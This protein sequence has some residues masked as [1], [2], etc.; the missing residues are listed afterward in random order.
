MFL[1]LFLPEKLNVKFPVDFSIFLP[2]RY[3][4]GKIDSVEI[5]DGSVNGGVGWALVGRWW[6]QVGWGG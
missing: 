1:F 5:S 3:S 6:G 2:E 4:K